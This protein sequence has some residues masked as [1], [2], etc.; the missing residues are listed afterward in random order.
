MKVS[1]WVGVSA[2][3]GMFLATTMRLSSVDT[4]AADISLRRR[5]DLYPKLLEGTG[6]AEG[7]VAKV[8]GIREW[9]TQYLGISLSSYCF[10]TPRGVSPLKLQD[11]QLYDCCTIP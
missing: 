11:V 9:V 1:G 10:F 6:L 8:A 5:Q 2:S 4:A 7:G 3:A